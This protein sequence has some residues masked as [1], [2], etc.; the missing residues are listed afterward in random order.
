MKG[1]ENF[2]NFDIFI[3]SNCLENWSSESPQQLGHSEDIV[4]LKIPFQ[5][6]VGLYYIQKYQTHSTNSS[7]SKLGNARICLC[8]FNFFC[9]AS[10]SHIFICIYSF[11]YHGHVLH[12]PLDPQ[13][14]SAQN[15]QWTTDQYSFSSLSFNRNPKHHWSFGNQEQQFNV[16]FGGKI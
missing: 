6:F 1:L 7:L 3:I 2:Q 4:L 8:D 12:F 14:I 5:I 10:D 9:C 11:S 13:I 15:T 16:K